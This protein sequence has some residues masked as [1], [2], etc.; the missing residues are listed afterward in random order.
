VILTKEQLVRRL[1][2]AVAEARELQQMMLAVTEQ[3]RAVDAV[4]TD[5]WCSIEFSQERLDRFAASLEELRRDVLS[6]L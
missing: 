6:D 4:E 1:D 3:T 2:C 5:A